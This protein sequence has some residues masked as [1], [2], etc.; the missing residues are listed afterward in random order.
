MKKRHNQL[1]SKEDNQEFLQMGA[2]IA[3]LR[4]VNRPGSVN[5]RRRFALPYRETLR[6]ALKRETAVYP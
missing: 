5:L 2:M 4:E 6:I 3:S 1:M